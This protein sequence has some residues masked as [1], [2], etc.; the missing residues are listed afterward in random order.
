MNWPSIVIQYITV[1]VILY[2][3]GTNI[4]TNKGMSI[5][6]WRLKIKEWEGYKNEN[7]RKIGHNKFKPSQ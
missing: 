4:I 2:L 5:Y 6:F 1:H 7:P 3:W